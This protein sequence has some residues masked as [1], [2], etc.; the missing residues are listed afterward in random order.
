MDAKRITKI[1]LSKFKYEKVDCQDKCCEKY[2]GRNEM[3]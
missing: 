1:D 3:E 2:H